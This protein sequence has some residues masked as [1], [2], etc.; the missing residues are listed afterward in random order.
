MYVGREFT[1]AAAREYTT[2]SNPEAKALER[3]CAEIDSL[4]DRMLRAPSVPHCNKRARVNDTAEKSGKTHTVLTM[5]AVRVLVAEDEVVRVT[6]PVF[7]AGPVTVAVDV[8]VTTPV[9]AARRGDIHKLW[10]TY[11]TVRLCKTHWTSTLQRLC[12]WQ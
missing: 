2:P 5:D 7:D 3:Y 1:E 11:T 12:H 6:V 10:C 4:M 9:A 8:D